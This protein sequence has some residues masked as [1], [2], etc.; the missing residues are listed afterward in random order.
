MTNPLEAL[1]DAG[2]TRT[3]KVAPLFGVSVPT[4]Y[5]WSKAGLL[6]PIVKL[7]PRASGM[8]NAALKECGA[9]LIGRQA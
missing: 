2:F 5:S 3:R 4:I 8:S 7:G 6:P 9:K 1:P